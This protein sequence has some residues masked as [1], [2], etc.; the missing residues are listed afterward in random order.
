MCS[1]NQCIVIK[2]HLYR[3]SHRVYTQL[4]TLNINKKTN[5]NRDKEREWERD[6]RADWYVDRVGASHW[7]EARSNSWWR[8]RSEVYFFPSTADLCWSNKAW[9]FFLLLIFSLWGVL[10]IGK[11]SWLTKNL[12]VFFIIIIFFLFGFFFP[13][14]GYCW[15][16]NLLNV[17]LYNF[18]SKRINWTKNIFYLQEHAPQKSKV[19]G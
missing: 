10:L 4:F 15:F 2:I 14:L 6:T 7:V 3:F 5:T 17:I 18:F 9:F 11:D 8:R 1:T 12:F 13:L 16:G 19:D